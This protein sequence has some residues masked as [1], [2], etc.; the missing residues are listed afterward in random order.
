GSISSGADRH[1]EERVE[2]HLVIRQL[3]H[4]LRQNRVARPEEEEGEGRTL[5]K[6]GAAACTDLDCTDFEKLQ[7]ILVAVDGDGEN[8]VDERLRLFDGQHLKIDVSRGTHAFLCSIT[9]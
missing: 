3:V 6:S 1:D 8:F 5:W 4:R 2:R 7:L 9:R